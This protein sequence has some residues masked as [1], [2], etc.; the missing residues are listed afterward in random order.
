MASEG[1][2]AVVGMKI[3]GHKSQGAYS[4]YDRSI[5]AQVRAAQKCTSGQGSGY[6]SNFKEETERFKN[7]VVDGR[8]GVDEDTISPPK[9]SKFEE[10]DL[11]NQLKATCPVSAAGDTEAANGIGPDSISVT[12]DHGQSEL[13]TIEEPEPAIEA[14]K[15]EGQASGDDEWMCEVNWEEIIADFR[16]EQALRMMNINPITAVLGRISNVTNCTVNITIES[17][18]TNDIGQKR[19]DTEG[20]NKENLG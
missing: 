18:N 10:P 2:P 7:T 15:N 5:D 1:V 9:K 17:L 4:R 16:K 8:K 13:V 12:S 20:A 6:S 14:N 19:M 11:L 3:L